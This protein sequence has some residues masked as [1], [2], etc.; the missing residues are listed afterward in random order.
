MTMKVRSWFKGAQTDD[1]ILV[2]MIMM[3]VKGVNGTNVLE[4]KLNLD[5][6]NATMDSYKG[7]ASWGLNFKGLMVLLVVWLCWPLPV[8]ICDSKKG[9][10]DIGENLSEK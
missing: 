3:I 6:V 5:A 1:E 2:I 8:Q 4:G 9:V 7:A 10:G